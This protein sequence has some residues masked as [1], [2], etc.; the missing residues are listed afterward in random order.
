MKM[1][2]ITLAGEVKHNGTIYS[3]GEHEVTP[4]LANALRVKDT[5]AQTAA[6]EANET[7]AQPQPVIATPVKTEK[8][9]VN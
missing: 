7:S 6:A 1:E 9:K 5:P 8:P 4:E 3:P 2:K